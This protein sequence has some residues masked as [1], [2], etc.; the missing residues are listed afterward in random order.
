[1]K[2]MKNIYFMIVEAKFDN[3]SSL[4]DEMIMAF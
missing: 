4:N 2:I 3:Y 1:M